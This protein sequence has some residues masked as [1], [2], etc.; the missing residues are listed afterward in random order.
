MTKR[1]AAQRPSIEA[2]RVESAGKL[3]ALL[4]D[5][6]RQRLFLANLSHE[7]LTP[8][9]SIKG[10]AQ[11]LAAGSAERPETRVKWT[12]VIERNADRLTRLIEDLLQLNSYG[13]DA[14]R[15]PMEGV[16]LREL[17]SEQVRRMAPRAVER[18]VSIHLSV[19]ERLTVFANPSELGIVIRNLLENAVKFNRRNG[20]V[21]VHARTAGKRALVSVSDTGIGIPKEH[22]PLIFDWFHREENAGLPSDRGNGLGL[23]IARAILLS[24]ACPIWAESSAGAGTRI[25]FTLPLRP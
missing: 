8:I 16:P 9:T 6:A 15:P 2:G 19:S 7:F 1:A 20:S 13:E 10:Y 18:K 4:A 24:R 14:S 25:R 5:E 22:L 21:R 12:K 11:T 23:S 3:A 17:V